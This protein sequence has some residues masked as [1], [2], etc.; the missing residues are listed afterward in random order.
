MFAEVKKN[1]VIELPFEII[2]EAKI[3][4]GDQ[5]WVMLNDSVI[6]LYPQ[7]QLSNHLVRITCFGKMNIRFFKRSVNIK[8]KNY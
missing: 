5:L 6:T 7:K 4:E 1:G 2:D 8:K 3:E